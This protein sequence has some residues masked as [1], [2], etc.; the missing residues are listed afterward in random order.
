MMKRRVLLAAVTGGLIAA[1]LAAQSPAIVIDGGIQFPDG[2]LQLT[3]A[4]QLGYSNRI[5]EFAP[6]KPYAEVCFK[7][8]GAPFS[9]DIDPLG[10]NSTRGGNCEPG[11]IGWVIELEER[12]AATWE[13]AKVD[14]LEDTMRLLEPFEWKYSCKNG[15]ALALVDLIDDWE[16]SSN[17]VVAFQTAAATGAVSILLGQEGCGWG[18]FSFMSNSAGGEGSHTYRCGR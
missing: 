6:P 18:T 1:G 17:V 4:T 15:L 11:D 2:T 8:G 3:A 16:W 7:G 14:C 10:G 12:G 5:V 13:Q 9:S